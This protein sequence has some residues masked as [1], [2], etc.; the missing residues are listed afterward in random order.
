LFVGSAVTIV[1]GSSMIPGDELGYH[2]D[3]GNYFYALSMIIS[4]SLIRTLKDRFV[5]AFA[6]SSGMAS[7][8][9]DLLAVVKG[10]D[11]FWEE[12]KVKYQKYQDWISLENG[13]G[14]W[15]FLT[16]TLLAFGAFYLFSVYLP[17]VSLEKSGGWNFMYVRDGRFFPSYLFNQ[18]K[19]FL[20]YV[21]LIPSAIWQSVLI[22]I[23]TIKLVRFIQ[24]NNAF[25]IIPLCPDNSGGLRALG[26]ISLTLF[27]I[28]IAQFLHLFA[29]SLV[30]NFP[31][32]HYFIYPFVCL[33]AI[34][35]FFF[36]LG[37]AHTSMKKA[38]EEELAGLSRR[39]Q[40]L[41]AQYRRVLSKPF[42]ERRTYLSLVTDLGAI[43]QLYR[44]VGKMPVWPYDFGTVT[45]F[46]SMLLIPVAVFLVQL[47]VNADSI[48][49]NAEKLPKLLQEMHFMIFGTG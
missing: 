15:I 25:E 27:Y 8:P 22:T 44:E 7:E 26:D 6:P 10:T 3:I 5:K 49:Y 43:R 20:V 34:F 24:R 21:I 32:S 39:H 30:L 19:D 28:V 45:K 33:L 41:Y 14:L 1:D 13:L 38:K 36:P 47:V 29:T 40:D 46:L 18:A 31:L 11:A 35:V 17:L 23:S 4:F 48:I 42:D 37:A 2:E 9:G 12:Y 16:L